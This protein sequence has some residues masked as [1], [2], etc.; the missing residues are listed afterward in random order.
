MVDKKD[1]MTKC[2]DRDEAMS[3]FLTD[4]PGKDPDNEIVRVQQ[5][6]NKELKK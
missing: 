6:G 3:D 2:Q 5:L 4:G 1:W